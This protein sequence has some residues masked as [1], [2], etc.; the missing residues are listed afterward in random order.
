MSSIP[1]NSKTMLAAV[2][3]CVDDTEKARETMVEYLEKWPD[4][5]L[6]SETQRVSREWTD[7]SIQERWLSDMRQAGMPE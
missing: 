1:D 4:R 7:V 3:I 2:Y 5:T 6:R